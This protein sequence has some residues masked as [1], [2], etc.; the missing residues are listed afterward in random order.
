MNRSF[1]GTSMAVFNLV[2]GIGFLMNGIYVW[3]LRAQ[4]GYLGSYWKEGLGGLFIML[5]LFIGC[6]LII[7]AAIRV[8][9]GDAEEGS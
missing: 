1:F 5:C 4:Y 8:V 3:F 7:S 9:D 6:A 2:G